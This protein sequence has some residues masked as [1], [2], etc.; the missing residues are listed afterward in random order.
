MSYENLDAQ[1]RAVC[2]AIVAGQSDSEIVLEFSVEEERV[3]MLRNHINTQGTSPSPVD[4]PTPEV[5]PE[6]PT[7]EGETGAGAVVD[8]NVVVDEST[9]EAPVDENT[10]HSTV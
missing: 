9:P 1:D 4:E 10:G 2:D 5:T 8:E 3:A 6:A 7:E